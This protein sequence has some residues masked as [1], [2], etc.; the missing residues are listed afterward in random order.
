MHI[1]KKRSVNL[2]EKS[3]NFTKSEKFT[4]KVE[5]LQKYKCNINKK[6]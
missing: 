1:F 4:E 3:M 5:I 2:T 6:V